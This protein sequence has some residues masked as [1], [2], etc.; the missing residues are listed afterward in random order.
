MR[1]L[2][3]LRPSHRRPH[4]C[5]PKPTPPSLGVTQHPARA[6]FIPL[7]PPRARESD[8]CP[9]AT[10]VPTSQVEWA[11]H[12]SRLATL[13]PLFPS[14]PPTLFFLLF[15]GCVFAHSLPLPLPLPPFSFSLSPPLPVSTKVSTK[16]KKD[17]CQFSR[18]C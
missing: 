18:C 10:T 8:A 16:K 7:H 17:A 11:T 12:L 6:P 1:A 5:H 2:S 13:T 3:G 9:L 15:A 4:R 14:S